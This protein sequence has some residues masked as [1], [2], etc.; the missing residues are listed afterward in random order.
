MFGV[1]LVEFVLVWAFSS[2][3][4][5][6]EVP[7]L[8]LSPVPE[9]SGPPG[10]PPSFFFH[11]AVNTWSLSARYLSPGWYS[12]PLQHTKVYPSRVGASMMSN[13]ASRSSL[14]LASNVFD[15][16]RQGARPNAQV[17][18]QDVRGRR[19]GRRVE[20]RDRVQ[21][22]GPVRP[23]CPRRGVKCG[24]GVY[25]CERGSGSGV[26]QSQGE[27]KKCLRSLTSAPS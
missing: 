26:C 24:S 7:E 20:R 27:S 1:L 12:E 23:P 14:S 19:G 22:P 13:H 8:L 9:S 25:F 18:P 11:S 6:P 5:E 2:E 10:F 21:R 15:L 17:R 4:L 16:R 3:P